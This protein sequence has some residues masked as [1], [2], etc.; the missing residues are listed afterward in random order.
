[1]PVQ[2]S[3]PLRR[4]RLASQLRRLREQ[5]GLSLEEAAK[6]LDKTRSTLGRIEQGKTR[7]DV[8]LVRTMMDIYDIRD[9][10]LLELAR[11]AAKK[12][13]WQAYPSG[14]GRSRGY[15]EWETEACEKLDLE[16]LY[17]PGL[18]Q[19]EAYMW[20]FEVNRAWLVARSLGCL[21]SV[22]VGVG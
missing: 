4:R 6:R 16:L 15:T 2:I 14:G 12:G 9:D 10:N 13:W 8:H 20:V 17:I 21:R 11:Q 7:A 1:M 19:T 18:L 3:P 5:A 22:T